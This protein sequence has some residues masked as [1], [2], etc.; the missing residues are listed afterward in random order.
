MDNLFGFDF[1]VDDADDMA[2]VWSEMVTMLGP[3]RCVRYRTNSPRRAALYRASDSDGVYR[4]LHGDDGGIEVMTGAQC[5][6]S[7]FGIHK[8]KVT[9]VQT[10]ILWDAVPGNVHKSELPAI[11][12]A[13]REVFLSSVRELLGDNMSEHS[14][15]PT[16]QAQMQ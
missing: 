14:I 6:L 9:Q 12:V 16:A 7:S 4:H 8:D 11:T 13:Q 15:D 3:P 1:D 2:V 5:K 10:P